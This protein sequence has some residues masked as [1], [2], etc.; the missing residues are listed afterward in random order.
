MT[1]KYR[2]QAI[3]VRKTSTMCAPWSSCLSNDNAKFGQAINSDKTSG[4]E[5]KWIKI[6]NW[7]KHTQIKANTNTNW[8]RHIDQIHTHTPMT[9]AQ[10]FSYAHHWYR[11]SRIEKLPKNCKICCV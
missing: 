5:G 9:Y 8:H 3:W 6:L 10:T 7:H 2:C 11:T 1:R 4:I